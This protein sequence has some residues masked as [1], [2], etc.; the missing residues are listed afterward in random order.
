MAGND[1]LTSIFLSIRGSLARAIAGIVPPKE[2]E[3]IVQETYVRVCQAKCQDGIRSPRKFLYKTAKNLALDHC[4]RSETRLCSSLDAE[5]A[6]DAGTSHA[7][8]KTFEQVTSNEEFSLFCEAVRHLP[9]QCRRVFVLKK[10]YGFTQREIADELNIEESTVEKHIA[11][12]VKRCTYFMMR[13]QGAE[14]G[15][16][17]ASRSKKSKTRLLRQE[18]R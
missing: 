7:S 11:L 5:D 13:H 8:D 16:K 6:F 2:I 18:I 1:S 14:D 12:G 4:K 3:D 10:V 15:A 17:D 9:V